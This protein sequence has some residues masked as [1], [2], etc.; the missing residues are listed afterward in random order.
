MNCS[1]QN[2]KRKKIFFVM[3]DLW[4]CRY[5]GLIKYLRGN[6]RRKR[7]GR[8]GLNL[9]MVAI[10]KLE[11]EWWVQDRLLYATL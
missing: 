2:L 11:G 3:I 5:V 6:E 4:W 8:G 10:E 7:K 1:S 9:Y